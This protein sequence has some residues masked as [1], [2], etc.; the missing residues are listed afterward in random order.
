MVLHTRHLCWVLCP[1]PCHQPVE[2]LAAWRGPIRAVHAPKVHVCCP[3]RQLV[4]EMWGWLLSQ[5]N[6]FSCSLA[7]VCAVEICEGL[8]NQKVGWG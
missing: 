8:P 1:A 3:Y 2:G 4:G 5:G 7:S 6:V